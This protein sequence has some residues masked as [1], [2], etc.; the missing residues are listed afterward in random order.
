M[1]N[2]NEDDWWP[3][4]LKQNTA[5]RQAAH[6]KFNALP[7]ESSLCDVCKSIDFGYFFF[8]DLATG[9]RKD[10]RETLSLGSLPTVY[11][12]AS[13]GCP[14]CRDIAIPTAQKLLERLEREER[15]FPPDRVSVQFSVNDTRLSRDVPRLHRSNGLY[16]GVGLHTE[17][18]GSDDSTVEDDRD[19]EPP[20]CLMDHE[21]STY[22]ELKP[23]VELENCK[24]WLKGCCDQHDQCNQT[25]ERPVDNER[26]KVIDVKRRR[27]VQ[28]GSQKGLRYA[29][30]SYVWGPVTDMWTLT[31]SME[32]MEDKE[33]MRYCVLPDT[34]PRTIEDAIQVTDGLDLPYLWVDA[35]CIIQNDADDKQ[36]QIGAMY[37][38][39]AEAEV[40]I[41]A[42]SGENAHSGL[43]GVSLP[44]QLPVSN[45]VTI[46][47]GVSVGIPQPPLQ[48]T[49]QSSKW[50]TRAWT[51]QELILSRRTL[52]FTEMETFFYCGFS[53]HKESAVYGGEGEEDYGWGDGDAVLIGNSSVMKARIDREPEVRG[54]VYVAAVEEYSVRQ[55]S[56]QSDGLNAFYGMSTYFGRLFQ[57]EMIYG[58]PKRMLVDCLKWTSPLVGPD[59]WPER[60]RLDD[61]GP[62]FPSWAWVAWK[63][64]VN[65]EL[66]SSYFWGSQI[67]FL[68]PSC[69]A[70]IPYTPALR[71]DFAVEPVDNRECLGGILPFITK[72]GRFQLVGLDLQGFADIY[73]LDGAYV[74][75]CDV[76]GCL[77]LEENQRLDAHIIQIMMRHRM[78]QASHCSAMVVRPHAWPPGSGL[79]A[80]LAA[81]ALTATSFPATARQMYTTAAEDELPRKEAACPPGIKISDSTKGIGPDQFVL[82]TRLGTAH[83]EAAVWE[84]ADLVDTVVFLG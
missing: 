4:S 67:K 26:F 81:Q 20:V 24:K 78:G 23:F 16:M 73:T 80:E 22:Q 63:G 36:A 25:Q 6:R 13:D 57:S 72:M 58:C 52:F 77:E 37:H 21:L 30:L 45:S 28:I 70:R 14:F 10:R 82:A 62:L 34:L 83:I 84:S 32:W 7:V 33:R 43:P 31:D 60:R 64:A 55:L 54:K 49:L 12:R 15:T 65:V 27:I 11:Q 35:V 17:S 40:N 42:A 46:R 59:S 2:W 51:Y 19:M 56:Y 71:Q 5:H 79:A 66:R 39:Y 69:F 74:G 1:G 18:V 68:E 75:D 53:L 38:I 29:T 76:R 47:K 8:G 41:V 9:Y 50:R 61:G 44:R 3:K 48:T